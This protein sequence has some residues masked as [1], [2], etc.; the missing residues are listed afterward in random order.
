VLATGPRPGTQ[1]YRILV[2]GARADKEL[3]LNLAVV[4]DRHALLDLLEERLADH[5]LE[6]VG[7]EAWERP[8][9]LPAAG[10]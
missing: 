3:F 6:K 2:E 5:G 10:A 8:Q 9:A 1:S 4:R 7:D